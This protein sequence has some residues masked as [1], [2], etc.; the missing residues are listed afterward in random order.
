M[1]AHGNVAV[2]DAR[3]QSAGQLG[4]RTRGLVAGEIHLHEAI[5]R[6][7]ETLPIEHVGERRPVDVGN[8]PLVANDVDGRRQ[9]C[10]VQRLAE[11]DR[12]DRRRAG[13]E[14]SC[15]GPVWS[16]F[17]RYP[18]SRIRGRRADRYGFRVA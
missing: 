18:A 10:R 8:A 14:A 16:C 15:R 17:R 13:I 7:D 11:R 9:R 12:F 5:A 3:R 1:R 4:H 6:H 2:D